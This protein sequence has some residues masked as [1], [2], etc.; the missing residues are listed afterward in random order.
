MNY[1][2][3]LKK[4]EL[5]ISPPHCF[6]LSITNASL[7]RKFLL[8][9]NIHTEKC[10]KYK[11]KARLHVRARSLSLSFSLS[12]SIYIYTHIHIYLCF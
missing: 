7:L 9:Y 12:L 6:L 2:P 10:T 4:V 8:R 11:F 1:F 3:L 5:L